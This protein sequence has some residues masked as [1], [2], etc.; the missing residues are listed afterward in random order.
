[1]SAKGKGRSV[2]M[3]LACGAAVSVAVTLAAV[4]VFAAAVLLCDLK[5]SVITPV[6]QVI[7]VVSILCGTL[8]AAKSVKGWQAGLFVGAA[9]MALGVILYC[10]FAGK[11]LPPAVIAGDMALGCAAGLLSGML[12]GTLKK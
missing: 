12:A 6:N 4:V 11:M 2:Q 10:A 8:A 5:S 7:K 9:Y 3:Q 1:M